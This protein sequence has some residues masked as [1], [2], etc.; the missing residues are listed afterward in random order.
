MRSIIFILLGM[1]FMSGYC[2]E[3]PPLVLFVTRDGENLS[4]IIKN[5]SG[6]VLDV[7]D[8]FK[9]QHDLVPSF[10]F[11]K[12]V[13]SSGRILTDNEVRPDGFWTSKFLSSNLIPTPVNTTKLEP[14]GVLN[15]KVSIERVMMGLKE[16]FTSEMRRGAV[17]VRVK[18][19]L[20]R[21]LRTFQ[22]ME[23]SEK[24]KEK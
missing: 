15:G 4:L 3:R 19:F 1:V 10:V 2:A 8:Q 13:D 23:W 6:K 16:G 9:D 5:S 20:D 17:S 24:A 11:L 12:I 22:E 7:Y 18:V 14:N 21:D